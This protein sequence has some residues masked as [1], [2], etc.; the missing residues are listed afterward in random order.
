MSWDA[1][2]ARI[3]VVDDERSMRTVLRTMLRRDGYEIREADNGLRALE[4]VREEGPFEVVLTDLKMP[5]IDGLE[6]LQILAEETPETAVVILTAHG[7]VDS[8]VQAVKR[9]AFDYLEKPFDRQHLRDTIQK[10]A[11]TALART[12]QARP[13]AV[14]AEGR[15]GF[16]GRSPAMQG[17]S[18]SCS[19]T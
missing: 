2:Q 3:L 4:L 9:G 14:E 1:S 10:A 8:A 5:G 16:V 17:P 19:P 13:V 7:S 11:A 12:R 18:R 15:Y 6:L